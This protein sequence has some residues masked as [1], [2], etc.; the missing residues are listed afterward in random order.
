MCRSQEALIKQR[1]E[2]LK[3]SLPT[4]A[5]PHTIRR[6]IS[7]AYSA[8]RATSAPQNLSMPGFHSM[9]ATF[10]PMAAFN[11]VVPSFNPMPN[12]NPIDM[13]MQNALREQQAQLQQMQLKYQQEQMKK[14][15]EFMKQQQE[16]QLQEQQVKLATLQMQQKAANEAKLIE[17]ETLRQKA[18][19]EA[20]ALELEQM[21]QK[22]ELEQKVREL[23]LE[24]K[25]VESGPKSVS[26]TTNQSPPSNSLQSSESHEK[27]HF[28]FTPIGDNPGVSHSGASTN[29]Q[30]EIIPNLDQH[31]KTNREAQ[32]AR[33]ERL[34][35]DFQMRHK[36]LNS[37]G[38]S[39][40]TTPV[41][42]E[43]TQ[44]YDTSTRTQIYEQEKMENERK[45]RDEQLERERKDRELAEREFFKHAQQSSQNSE[46][47]DHERVRLERERAE[48]E[49]FEQQS[50]SS[51]ASRLAADSVFSKVAIALSSDVGKYNVEPDEAKAIQ[52]EPVQISQLSPSVF[53]LEEEATEF[54][55]QSDADRV[56]YESNVC[57]FFLAL[58]E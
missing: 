15:Q 22:L 41:L 12:L 51:M 5:D 28:A 11:P 2:N 16:V 34:R 31:S 29:Q 35:K 48:R 4:F 1:R 13:E 42:V 40:S 3:N 19:T 32:D 24:V 30:K 45:Q 50:S 52:E 21:K 39:G 36:T 7:E 54:Q 9:P 46:P 49:L 26:S 56:Q 27:A 53:A 18:A 33:L 10:S 58:V 20:K 57:V 37:G 17:L 23:Q 38:Q 47:I 8:G 14:Q 25:L 55:R 44:I 43:V 6:A